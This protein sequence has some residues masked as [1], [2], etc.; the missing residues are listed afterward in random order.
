M[1][2]NKGFNLVE[3][4]I[5]VTIL[6][7][8]LT[9]VFTGKKLIDNARLNSVM[10]ELTELQRAYNSFDTSYYGLPGDIENASEYWSDSN[11]IDGNGN[12]E[13]DGNYRISGNTEGSQPASAEIVNAFLQLSLSQ[14]YDK[15][16]DGTLNSSAP[17]VLIDQ[18]ILGAKV[19]GG[20]FYYWDGFGA[21]ADYKNFI[22]FAKYDTV[23]DSAI[24]SILTPADAKKI[25]LKFDNGV[26]STGIV[27]GFNGDDASDCGT[28]I[29]DTSGDYDLT[30]DVITCRLAVKLD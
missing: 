15:S 9:A 14:I 19:A 28:N 6:T 27:R 25:D 26:A 13:I 2:N 3:L 7:L 22:H 11:I 4:A 16:L 5:V 29:G 18:N 30:K 23:N 12:R 8:L 20:I 21:I 10:V 24:A 1:H 17:Y